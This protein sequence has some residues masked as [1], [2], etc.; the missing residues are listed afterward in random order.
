MANLLCF[1]CGIEIGDRLLTL[2][3]RTILYVVDITTI[4]SVINKGRFIFLF[5]AGLIRLRILRVRRITFS[6]KNFVS[7]QLEHVFNIL[8]RFCACFNEAEL[9]CFSEVLQITISARSSY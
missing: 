9:V 2:V 5:Y 1:C 3:T 8:I 7:N 6:F 4:L